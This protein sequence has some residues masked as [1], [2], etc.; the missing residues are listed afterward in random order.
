MDEIN[1]LEMYAETSLEM[2]SAEI[3]PRKQSIPDTPS[4]H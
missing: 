4:D 2:P 3:S 1:C